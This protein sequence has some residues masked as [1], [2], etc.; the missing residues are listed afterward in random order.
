MKG[1][2]VKV[3][4]YG[5]DPGDNRKTTYCLEQRSQMRGIIKQTWTDN[6]IQD[7]LSM[8]ENRNGCRDPR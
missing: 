6:V 3:E 8:E 4:M 1:L 5:L 2:S 7:H